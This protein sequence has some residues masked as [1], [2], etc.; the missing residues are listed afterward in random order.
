[1]ADKIA[2]ETKLLRS[3]RFCIL[4]FYTTL[5]LPLERN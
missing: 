5:K 4:L 1:M 2:V 3:M